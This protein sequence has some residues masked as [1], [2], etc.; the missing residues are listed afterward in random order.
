MRPGPGGLSAGVDQWGAWVTANHPCRGRTC[1]LWVRKCKIAGAGRRLWPGL[2]YGSHCTWGAVWLRRKGLL[3]LLPDLVHLGKGAQAS[4]YPR[5]KSEC[6]HDDVEKAERVVN[7][8]AEHGYEI[9]QKR[10]PKHR[11]GEFAL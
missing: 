2:N 4:S 11:S 5:G 6:D 1:N 3:S 8:Q 7:H 10:R 9:R